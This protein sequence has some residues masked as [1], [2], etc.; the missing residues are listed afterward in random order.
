MRLMRGDKGAVAVPAAIFMFALTLP[1][2]VIIIDG[3]GLFTERRQLQNSADA[4]AL[5]AAQVC[6]EQVN[7]GNCVQGMLYAKS[8]SFVEDNDGFDSGADRN[9]GVTYK[10]E[11]WYLCG[12]VVINSA[13]EPVPCE[14][15]NY[16]SGAHHTYD[17]PAI[18]PSEDYVQ[19][20]VVSGSEGWKGLIDPSASQ[21]FACSRAIVSGPHEVYT[22]IDPVPEW[23][24]AIPVPGIPG[25]VDTIPGTPP[26]SANTLAFT[27][28]LCVYEKKMAANG[29]LY[30]SGTSVKYE[31]DKLLNLLTGLGCPTSNINSSANGSL[32]GAKTTGEATDVDIGELWSQDP[33]GANSYNGVAT[34]LA[35]NPSTNWIVPVYDKSGTYN[36]TGTAC[37]YG[38]SGGG[39]NVCYHIVGFVAFKITSY[40]LSGSSLYFQG[41]FTTTLCTVSDEC[42]G[43]G[44]DWGVTEP[45]YITHSPSPGSTSYVTHPPIPG[46]T[47]TSI[48]PGDPSDAKPVL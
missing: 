38:A 22:Y 20:R 44:P 21:V 23:V 9:E 36:K 41:Y 16:P 18:P 42:S 26:S 7:V 39:T 32:I 30:G 37:N 4:G 31:V 47:Q 15:V 6:S 1:L 8:K 27:M 33:G 34:R 11:N 2:L 17:C 10:Q 5:A 43:T 24:E 25:W 46:S 48:A 35:A 13:G 40:S 19:V 45:T 12:S 3:G 28:P 29:G 14:P